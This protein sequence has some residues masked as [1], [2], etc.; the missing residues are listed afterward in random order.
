MY[1][2]SVLCKSASAAV[3]RSCRS[4]TVFAVAAN[5]KW[6]WYSDQFLSANFCTILPCC[7]SFLGVKTCAQRER[8]DTGYYLDEFIS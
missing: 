5:H 8:E 1:F 4:N 7:T 3:A 2:E 6:W